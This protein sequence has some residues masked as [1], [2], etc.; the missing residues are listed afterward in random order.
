MLVPLG[1]CQ[2]PHRAALEV[3]VLVQ[4]RTAKRP[5]GSAGK[6]LNHDVWQRRYTAQR[7]ITTKAQA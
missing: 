7:A 6:V 3:I 2:E 1:R 5:R 4:H